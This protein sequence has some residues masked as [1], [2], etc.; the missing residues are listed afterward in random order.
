MQLKHGSTFESHNMLR[1]RQF[2][3]LLRIRQELRHDSFPLKQPL[4]KG[5]VLN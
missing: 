5:P 2:G 3:L 1:M 4:Q